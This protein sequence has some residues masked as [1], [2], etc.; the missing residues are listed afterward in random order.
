MFMRTHTHIRSSV[1][2]LLIFHEVVVKPRT[3][4]S[5]KE[6]KFKNPTGSRLQGTDKLL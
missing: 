2:K 1:G 5:A 4:F 6:I 3:E